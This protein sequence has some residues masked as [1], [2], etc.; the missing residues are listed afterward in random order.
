M[1]DS[2]LDLLFLGF[3]RKDETRTDNKKDD[4]DEAIKYDFNE[5]KFNTLDS[6]K[7]I[8]SIGTIFKKKFTREL[9]TFEL[10]Y[11]VYQFK[12]NCKFIV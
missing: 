8:E 5:F 1:D 9:K 7:T 12:K 6:K 4:K 11:N 3:N 10:L 2:I